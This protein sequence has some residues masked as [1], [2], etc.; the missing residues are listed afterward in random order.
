MFCRMQTNS[1]ACS[2]K[3]FLPF[4]LSRIAVIVL[5]VAFQTHL[6]LVA[7]QLALPCTN[8]AFPHVI[9]MAR[10]GSLMPQG[11]HRTIL[12]PIGFNDYYPQTYVP[13]DPT[14]ANVANAS[15]LVWDHARGPEILGPNP[16]VEFMFTIPL[17][18]HE[19]PV[20]EPNLNLFFFSALQANTPSQYVV[21]LNEDPPTLSNRTSNP[22]INLSTGATFKDGLIYTSGSTATDG[23]FTAS[24][25]SLNAST[26][27]ATPI[28]NNYFGYKFTTIDDL[29]FAPNGDIWF[30]DDCTQHIPISRYSPQ[31][32]SP[33][34]LSYTQR[35]R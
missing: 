27:E 10:Y 34:S 12:F 25:N 3:M 35:P 30:T 5:F 13:G 19:A 28:L 16:E 18:G 6:S 31:P 29:A 33:P 26:G 14:F 22:P 20:Y 32:P 2:M 8:Y 24:I 15:F 17:A 4:L 1:H 23:V 11:F 9:C 21:D 7:A